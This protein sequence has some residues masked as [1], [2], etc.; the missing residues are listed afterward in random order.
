M[1]SEFTINTR[2]G[3]Y[4]NMYPAQGMFENPRNFSNF[5]KHLVLLALRFVW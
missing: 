5:C 3:K 2:Q 4:G 1:R